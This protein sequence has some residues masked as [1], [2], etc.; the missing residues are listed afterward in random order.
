MGMC[1]GTAMVDGH[2]HALLGCAIVVA[3]FF[4]KVRMEEANLRVAFGAGYDDY[5]RTTVGALPG[6]F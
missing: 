4:R 3:A 6:L 1:L 2:A 5:R